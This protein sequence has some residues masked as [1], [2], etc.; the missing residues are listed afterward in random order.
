[1]TGDTHYDLEVLAELAEGLLDDTTARRVREH[2]AVCDPCGESLADLAAVR[3]VLAAMPVPAMPLGVARRIDQALAAEAPDW[4]RVLRDAPWDSAPQ[5]I[6]PWDSTSWDDVPWETA[7]PPVATPVGTTVNSAVETHAEPEREPVAASATAAPLGVVADDGTIVPARRRSGTRTGGRKASRRR[8]WALPAAVAA[9]AA[10]VIGSGGL[11]TG[12]LSFGDSPSQQ[13]V[14]QGDPAQSPAKVEALT[15]STYASGHNYTS[16]E[17]RGPLL[18]YFGVAPGSGTNDD[19]D[20]D[21]CVKRFSTQ[22]DR[23]PIGVDKALYNGNEATVM[24]FWEDKSS[25]AVRVVVVDSQCH[26]LR[27]EVLASWK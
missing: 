16:R 1:M 18:G 27:P 8:T 21:T 19:E 11:A 3:E 6:A 17:L 5:E 14:S 25:N 12:L 26:K 24:A 10:V 22:L 20:L 4:N 7:E 9:A 2:L 15:Y 13:V 23:A